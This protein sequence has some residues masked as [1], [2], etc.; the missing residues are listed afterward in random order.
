MV[1]YGSQ[2]GSFVNF[3]IVMVRKERKYFYPTWDVISRVKGELDLH[4]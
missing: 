1:G 4:G 3:L 2:R